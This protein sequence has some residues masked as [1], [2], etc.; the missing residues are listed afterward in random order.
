MQ[1]QPGKYTTP[2]TL[3]GGTI[4]VGVTAEKGAY[5]DLEQE[6]KRIMMRN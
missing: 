6:A 5:V 1:T 4:G 2:G 3:K